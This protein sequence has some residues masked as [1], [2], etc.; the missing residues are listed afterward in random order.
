MLRISN[1]LLSLSALVFA[2][3]TGVAQA[4]KFAIIDMQQAV[5]ATTD[6]KRASQVINDKFTP[7][8]TQIDQMAKDIQ[9][10]QDAFT[11]NRS[12][13]SPAAATA[14]QQEIETLTTNLKR[15]Q[16]D[17]QQDLEDEE[18]KQLGGIVPKM[19]QIVNQYAAA[20]GISF[21]IDTS[22]NPNNLIYG[23]K[24]INISAQ[25]VAAYEKANGLA[26]AGTAPA[27]SKP[28]AAPAAHT[29][30]STA[31]TPKTAPKTAAP[32]K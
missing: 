11:K 23:D 21:V 15:K 7:V 9:V 30:A 27:A 12:T 25:I 31:P 14:A 24:S 8:K 20:N 3:G 6:G 1:R 26:P 22:A 32:A 16:E 17:A 29:P 28:A 10:K 4:Q 19:Q 2:L 13:L 18:N 5:L